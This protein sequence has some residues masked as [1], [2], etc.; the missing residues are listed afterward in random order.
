MLSLFE[1]F[2]VQDRMA[3]SLT[4]T[5]KLTSENL[6]E[7]AWPIIQS[8][9]ELRKPIKN[10]FGGTLQ[11]HVS[12]N[13]TVTSFIVAIKY[14]VAFHYVKPHL[15]CMRATKIGMMTHKEFNNIYT[16][17]LKY[18]R[19]KFYGTAERELNAITNT[20][21]DGF[22]RLA[23]EI[24]SNKTQEEKMP[25]MITKNEEIEYS[26]YV[27]IAESRT[28]TEWIYEE[29]NR[30]CGGHDWVFQSD[31]NWD[32]YAAKSSTNNKQ[33]QSNCI[34][35]LITVQNKRKNLNTWPT[36]EN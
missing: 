8:Y 3:R 5:P 14:Q 10:S 29:R 23:I 11:S 19:V 6:D 27:K 22:Q 30:I 25:T 1:V 12:F 24:K 32:Q 21:L 33:M 15:S 36:H 17:R 28:W 4:F 9:R 34:L 20:Q 26:P 13:M 18:Y 31:N 7:I 35:S 16:R 2:E